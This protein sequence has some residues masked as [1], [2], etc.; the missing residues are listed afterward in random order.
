[1][2]FDSEANDKHEILK[3]VGV[4][5]LSVYAPLKRFKSETMAY[6]AYLINNNILNL[7]AN[8]HSFLFL[9][10]DAVFSLK[11]WCYWR[12]SSKLILTEI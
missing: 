5:S 12:I 8:L 9:L 2:D 1:M 7:N 11:Y 3:N 10:N 6:Q 4:L